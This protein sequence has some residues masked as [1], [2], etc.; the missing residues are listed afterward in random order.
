M[1]WDSSMDSST[2]DSSTGSTS[3]GD[4]STEYERMGY[5][6]RDFLVTCAIKTPFAV[7]GFLCS[8]LIFSV[9]IAKPPIL[10]LIGLIVVFVAGVA[11]NLVAPLQPPAT[12]PKTS[13]TPLTFSRYMGPYTAVLLDWTVFPLLVFNILW[14][15]R[16]L[17]GV[18]SV[19]TGIYNVSASDV[20]T[21]KEC[22]ADHPVSRRQVRINTFADLSLLLV[23]LWYYLPVHHTIARM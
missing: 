11:L 20:V 5:P 10:M 19:V 4:S 13:A 15:L 12:P 16:W 18:E 23:Y 9:Q 21:L 2:R 7:V 14:G 1:G 3:T 22:A 8:V 6:T 17:I